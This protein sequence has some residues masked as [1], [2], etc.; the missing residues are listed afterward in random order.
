MFSTGSL[1]FM[2]VLRIVPTFLGQQ[3]CQIR[4]SHSESTG[5]CTVGQV[6]NACFNY[7]ANIC[8][9]SSSVSFLI[10]DRAEQ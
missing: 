2:H 10:A 3:F 5:A 6:L 4:A 1:V 7:C 8:T 9:V